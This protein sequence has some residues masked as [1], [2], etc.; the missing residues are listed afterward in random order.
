MECNG[1]TTC[2]LDLN[3]Q[4]LHICKWR[5]VSIQMKIFFFFV[6]VYHR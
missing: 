1:L 4:Y 6:I 5:K 2:D 3:P